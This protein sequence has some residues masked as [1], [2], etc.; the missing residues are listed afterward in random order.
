MKIS[1]FAARTVVRRQLLAIT[2]FA[3]IGLGA[4]PHGPRALV[5]IGLENCPP[6]GVQF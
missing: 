3:V 4:A 1:V 6:I 2:M 5:S